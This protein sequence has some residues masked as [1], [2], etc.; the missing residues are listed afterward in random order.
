MK[1][2]SN[3]PKDG[4]TVKRSNRRFIAGLTAILMAVLPACNQTTPLPKQVYPESYTTAYQQIF[5]HCYDSLPNLAVVAL[6]LYSKGLDLDKD[7]LIRGTGYNLYLSDIFVPDS[8]L[9][10]GEYTS[11][12]NNQLPIT[13][14]TF[15]PGKDYGG[16]PHGIYLLTIENSQITKIQIFDSGSFVYRNDSLLFTL[17]YTN[18]EGYPATY[19]CN[20]SGTLIPWVKK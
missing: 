3:S 9:E 1:K 18:A 17:Y 7:S 4:L 20:F 8:L 12:T 5:G 15:L 19:N 16:T 11:I 6:D 2:F 10:E 14:F 13:A